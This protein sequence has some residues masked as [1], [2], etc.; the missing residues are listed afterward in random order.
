M[1]IKN[2]SN[3]VWDY[4]EEAFLGKGDHGE[5]YRVLHLKNHKAFAIKKIS[6]SHLTVRLSLCRSQNGSR[7]LIWPKTCDKFAASI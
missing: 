6:I 5:V 2:S 4:R 7:L 1:R 3:N